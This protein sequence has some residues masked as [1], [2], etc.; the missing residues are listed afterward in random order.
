MAGD[1]V[2]SEYKVNFVAPAVGEKLTAVGTVIKAGA[3]QVV[4]RADV[5]AVKDGVPK[6]CA[7]ALSTIARV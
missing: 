2:T 5:F 6:I 4:A 1:V 3:R 7:T